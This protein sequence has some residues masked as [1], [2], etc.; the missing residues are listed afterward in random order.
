MHRRDIVDI[1]YRAAGGSCVSEEIAMIFLTNPRIVIV[2]TAFAL[3][4]AMSQKSS[5]NS[6]K[7][8]QD[9][10]KKQAERLFALK[11]LPL[12]KTKCFGCHGGDPDDVKGK[13][14]IR[15]R[16]EII[17]GGESGEASVVPGKPEESPLYRAVLR[18]GLEMPPKEND[19]L[20]K[21]ETELI[22][23]WIA[24]GA[25]WPDEA[26]RNRIRKQEWEKDPEHA[27]DDL[28]TRLLNSK[29]YG[30]RWGQHW[31]DVVRYA[32]TAGFSND[33]ER[34]NAWRYRDYV[35]RSFSKDKPFNEFT[36]EQIAGDE[37]RPDDPE[38]IVAT[39]MLRMGPWGTA[40][41][42]QEE[43]RQIYL[44]DLVHTVSQAFLSI[45]MCCCKCHDHKFDPIPTRDYY[46]MYAIF[47]TILRS[48]TD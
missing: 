25:P 15:S 1:V 32:D 26:A 48:V 17:R 8:G 34:S 47:A 36:L 46:R 3:I 33:Y 27:W 29:H 24:A 4:A 16:E 11:I 6:P 5:A 19:R 35:I 18:D 9:V 45:P 31:L 39:G 41:I 2:I 10:A 38:A 43:A 13:F 23:K 44:D 12:F 37:L 42:P 21:E 40:M 30:E 7:P 22:R 28:I 20:K 14:D